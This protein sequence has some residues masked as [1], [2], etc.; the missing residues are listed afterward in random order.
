MP[1]IKR[2]D[3]P[4]GSTSSGHRPKRGRRNRNL[5]LNEASSRLIDPEGGV[6]SQELAAVLSPSIVWLASF[7]GKKFH[8]QCTGIVVRNDQ[9]GASFV[10]SRDLVASR[11]VVTAKHSDYIDALRIKVHLPNGRVVNASVQD[12]IVACNMIVV[13]TK[14]F[15]DLRP[16][17][18]DKQMQVEPSIQLLAA[19]LC[20]MSGK[21]LVTTGVLTDSPIGVETHGIMWS[22]CKITEVLC[23]FLCGCPLAVSGG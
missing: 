2:G 20:H 10:T 8:S 15:P 19:S 1:K 22:T 3:V 9:L 14:S 4:N 16:A 23:Q 21:F 13:G 6:L 5:H 11:D 18:L 12:C 7:D 17:C